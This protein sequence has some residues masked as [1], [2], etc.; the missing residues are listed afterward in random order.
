MGAELRGQLLR[1]P[2]SVPRSRDEAA[3]VDE[4]DEPVRLWDVP[5]ALCVC[6]VVT[7]AGFGSSYSG[8]LQVFVCVSWYGFVELGDG[9][10]CSANSQ[11]GSNSLIGVGNFPVFL[12]WYFDGD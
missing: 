4:L 2:G 3:V 10:G 5:C 11:A 12:L 8:W 6:V 7:A 9:A 1:L